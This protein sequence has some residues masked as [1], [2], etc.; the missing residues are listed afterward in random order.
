MHV[1]ATMT[2]APGRAETVSDLLARSLPLIGTL[3][4]KL[5][6]SFRV[7]DG[8]T[9]TLLNLWDIPDANAFAN[10]PGQIAQHPDLAK[11][12]VGLEEAM[13][14][15]ELTLMSQTAPASPAAAGAKA[16]NEKTVYLRETVTALP[17]QARGLAAL[18]AQSVPLLEKQG[19]RFLGAWR[20]ATGA[21]RMTMNLWQ[22]PASAESLSIHD[23]VEEDAE[24]AKTFAAIAEASSS[25]ELT[26]LKKMPFSP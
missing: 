19:F 4:W 6:G 5:G 1:H 26:Y 12:M 8:P 23:I 2:L 16:A 18:L 9:R 13:T 14:H 20:R 11:I 24:V 25:V 17:G 21:S 10:L 7:L 22:L 3:G 15:N